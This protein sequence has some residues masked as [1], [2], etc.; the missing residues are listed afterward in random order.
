MTA[1]AAEGSRLHFA[2]EMFE[3]ARPAAVDVAAHLLAGLLAHPLELAM[4]ELDD[5]RVGA[6]GDEADLD[7]G[8][9]WWYRPSSGN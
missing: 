1:Q 8:A 7:L 4:L 9:D 6:V 3:H 2:P 5:G